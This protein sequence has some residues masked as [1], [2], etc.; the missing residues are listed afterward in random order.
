MTL[1]LTMLHTSKFSKVSNL[2][3]TRVSTPQ[4]AVWGLLFHKY[5]GENTF[6]H[7]F[8][9]SR[10]IEKSVRHRIDD[11]IDTDAEAQIGKTLWILRPVG[12][13]P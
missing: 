13:L 11:V 8:L 12:P 3:V 5:Y 2:D 6:R 1:P 10:R 9:V 4:E 7:R